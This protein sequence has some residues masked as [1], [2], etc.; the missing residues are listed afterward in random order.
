MIIDPIL[1][2]GLAILASVVLCWPI[3]QSAFLRTCDCYCG[4]G[5]CQ[6]ACGCKDKCPC[7]YR[8]KSKHNQDVRERLGRDRDFFD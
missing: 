6:C 1:G 2:I 5:E 3:L 4:P 7:Y 8:N